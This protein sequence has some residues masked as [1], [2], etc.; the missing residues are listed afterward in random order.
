LIHYL[1]LFSFF[2][3]GIGGNRDS[4]HIVYAAHEFRSKGYDV[5][6][7]IARGCGGLQL[8]TPESFTAARTTDLLQVLKHIKSTYPNRDIF[9]VGYSLGAGILL[10]YLGQTSENSLLSAAVAVSPSWN[11]LL[12]TPV[13]EWWSRFRLVG[14]SDL[15]SFFLNSSSG[16]L[17]EYLM[18]HIH[19]LSTHPSN[20]VKIKETLQAKNVREFDHSA[21]VPV[22]GYRDVD[23]YYYDASAINHSRGITT[24]T[25]ALSSDDDPVCS[26]LGC[27]WDD[28][29]IFG[30]GLVVARTRVGGH[31]AF[32]TFGLLFG[33]TTSWMDIVALDWFEAYRMYKERQQIQK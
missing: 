33:E 23:H 24:P 18:D 14:N 22:H 12:S 27:P 11:F 8:T 21:V 4:N 19:Y 28:L 3:W 29:S 15:N 17:R 25:L 30:T 31:V 32:S 2:F 5:V 10:K 7:F 6:A 13:F 16:G 1:F 26:A 20:L 9:A